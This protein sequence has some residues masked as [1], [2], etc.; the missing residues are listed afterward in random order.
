MYICIHF[1]Q[2][3]VSYHTL[4]HSPSQ[5]A[6]CRFYVEMDCDVSR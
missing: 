6:T 1:E 2:I 5:M 3:A 4:Q